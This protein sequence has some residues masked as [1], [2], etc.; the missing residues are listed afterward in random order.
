MAL[1]SESTRVKFAR[2]YHLFVVE[3]STSC[4]SIMVFRVQTM[5]AHDRVVSGTR[6]VADGAARTLGSLKK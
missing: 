5:F 2:K 3:K 6:D 4:N 1:Q